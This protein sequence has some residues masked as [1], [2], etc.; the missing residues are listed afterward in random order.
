MS[1]MIKMLKSD[2]MI[3]ITIGAGFFQKLTSAL[4][5]LVDQHSEEEMKLLQTLM[6]ENK[7]LPEPW[8][9]NIQ[10]LM[11][12]LAELEKSAEANGFMYDQSLDDDL[13]KQ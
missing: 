11:V 6:S 1:Q 12:L 8:M 7:E 9:E 13:T 4:I 3:P 2:A 10:T 5:Y